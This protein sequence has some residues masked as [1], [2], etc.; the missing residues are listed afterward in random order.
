LTD[1]IDEMIADII[2]REGGYNDI[3]EDRGGATNFG[4]SLRYAVGVGLDLN[5]DG[6]VDNSDIRLVTPERAGM[7]YRDDFFARPRIHRL[8]EVIQPQVF[9]CAVNH[10]PPRAIMFVQTVVNECQFGPVSVDGVIG[11][12][13]VAAAREAQNGMGLLFNNA[14]MYERIRFYEGLA[15]RDPS[16][17]KFLNGWLRRAREFEA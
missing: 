7:M 12:R 5:G 10:G 13:T 17:I 1:R 9:D 8:P 6:V 11:P 16:Q 15:R 3:A 2:R 4:V 14:I